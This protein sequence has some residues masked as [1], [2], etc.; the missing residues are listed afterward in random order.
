MSYAIEAAEQ[1]Q[2]D[3]GVAI[4]AVLVDD[5]SGEVVAAGGSMVGPTQDPTAH[6]EIMCI[7]AAAQRLGSDDLYGHTLYSTL[8]PCQ[9]CLSA[10]AWAKIPHIVF[11][12]YRKD[13]DATLF[14]VDG[15]A[16]DESEAARMNLREPARMQATGGVLETACARLLRGYHERPK[17]A[18]P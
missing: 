9:M 18:D 1:A 13:V 16:S 3:D 14:D 17:H 4:G 6:A 10:A 2:E 15:A 5:T 12:A 7:R 11:G 8:E